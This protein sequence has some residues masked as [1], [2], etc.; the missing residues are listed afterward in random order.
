MAPASLLGVEWCPPL[1]FHIFFIR[2]GFLPDPLR[3]SAGLWRRILRRIPYLRRRFGGLRLWFLFFLLVRGE[4]IIIGLLPLE[5]EFG[6]SL[7][8][9]GRLLRR[10]ALLA[11]VSLSLGVI[12]LRF[13]SL[14]VREELVFELL[15]KRLSENARRSGRNILVP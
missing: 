8:L 4:R 1:W 12:F 5:L 10:S 6:F 11:I 14:E 13:P 2:L 9:W 7:W 15:L 3:H